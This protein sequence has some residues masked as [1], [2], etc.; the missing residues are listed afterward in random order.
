MI[1]GRAPNRSTNRPT[2]GPAK[3]PSALA[4]LN[5]KAVWVLLP[6]ITVGVHTI[7]WRDVMLY[8]GTNK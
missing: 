1:K 7:G 4:R 2:M 8:S 3:L 5:I 6:L